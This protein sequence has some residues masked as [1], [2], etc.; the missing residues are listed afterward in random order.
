MI[1]SIQYELQVFETE[2]HGQFRTLDID[3]EPWFVLGEVCR[4][5]GLQPKNGS[6]WHHAERLDADEKRSVTRS[7]LEQATSPFKGEVGGRAIAPTTIVINESGLYSIILRSEKPEAKRFKKWITSE[8]LPSIRRSGAYVLSI[9]RFIR[10]F[11]DNWERVSPGCFSIISEAVIRLWGRLEQLGHVMADISPDGREL[12]PDVSIG[13]LFS[14][15]LKLK[16][17]D[18]ADNYTHYYHVT[19]DGEFPAR[20]YPREM[21]PLYIEF[22]DTVWIPQHAPKY[23]KDRDPKA[24]AFLPSLLPDKSKA[25]PALPSKSGALPPP[26]IK[27]GR[28][29]L[30]PRR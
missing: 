5:V 29:T 13:R 10:R 21:L 15:W 2:D 11:N 19:S 8:V 24:L 23:F 17:S 16:H 28:P 25:K 20:E 27:K 9:P 12:R 1:Q 6:F 26:R 30:E 7:V 18:V 22:L 3:G 4:A 14:E